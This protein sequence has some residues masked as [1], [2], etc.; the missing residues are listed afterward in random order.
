MNV[1]SKFYLRGTGTS[2]RKSAIDCTKKGGCDNGIDAEA[3]LKFHLFP[4]NERD[5]HEICVT[6]RE[7]GRNSGPR[8]AI[9]NP[10]SSI[11]D[12]P[13]ILP[14]LRHIPPHNT[15]P[16]PALRTDNVCYLY[17]R[18]SSGCRRRGRG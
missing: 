13:H 9:L 11:L 12:P 16:P 5:F 18:T 6:R 3:T 4:G 10:R 14:L 2:R 17:A 15:R 8:I 7:N 1:P